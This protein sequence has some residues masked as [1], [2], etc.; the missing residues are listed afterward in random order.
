[1]CVNSLA[2]CKSECVQV[3]V[4]VGVDCEWECV[5]CLSE[6]RERERYRVRWLIKEL[7]RYLIICCY[8]LGPGKGLDLSNLFQKLPDI[9]FYWP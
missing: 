2:V 4:S 6:K 9:P 7:L 1:M 3:Q 5:T 8:D